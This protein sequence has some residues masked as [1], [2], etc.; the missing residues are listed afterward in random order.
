MIR[1]WRCR[2]LAA[3]LVDYGEETLAPAA[4]A[5]VARHLARCAPCAET[6]AALTEVPALLRGAP[7]V[8]EEAAWAMQR[9]RIM[10]AIRTADAPRQPRPLFG[11]DWRLALPAAAAVAIALAGYLSL[12]AP[13]VPGEVVLDTLAP[14]DLA[15]L[16]EVGGG[17]VAPP[18]AP[19]EVPLT[20]N[21]VRG[22][23]EAGWV[24]P[25]VLPV[26]AGWGD[27]DD[28]DLDT[29]NGMVG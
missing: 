19:A 20:G 4:R 1:N 23:L 5:R 8:R 16:E 6:R 2:R 26:S 24:H 17:I 3:A 28:D 12:R 21:A 18:D 27:L 15:A 29:L 25:D 14:E 10:E 9:Q 13:S 22:A 7:P 11:F